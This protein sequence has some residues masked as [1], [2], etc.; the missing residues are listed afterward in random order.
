M[1]N[2]LVIGKK[3]EDGW[4]VVQEIGGV[5]RENPEWV[6]TI[7]GNWFRQ[8]DGRKIGYV[9]I[10]V[11]RPDGSRRHMPAAKPSNWD[12]KIFQNV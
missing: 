1:P 8:S 2:G 9:L 5:V 7:Q 11:D 10:D 6:W 4:G 3:Y 12:L